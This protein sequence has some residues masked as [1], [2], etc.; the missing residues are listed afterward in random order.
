[1]R[2]QEIKNKLID[3]LD[4]DDLLDEF[5][6]DNK[7]EIQDDGADSAVKLKRLELQ[8]ET[9]MVKFKLEQERLK[10]EEEER[11]AKLQL[12]QERWKIEQKERQDRLAMEERIKTKEIE[13]KFKIEKDKL[14]K[15]GSSNS[16]TQSGFDATKNIRL[17][18]KFEEKEVDKYFLHFEKIANS[19]K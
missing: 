7:I 4:E 14:E 6:L 5:D 16:S 9:E 3:R 12:E 10:I 2:K 17:V 1:M 13:A 19:L 11:K 18:P 8:Q 15:Q